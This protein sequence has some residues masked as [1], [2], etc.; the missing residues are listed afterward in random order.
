MI[1]G[2]PGLGN[3]FTY[4]SGRPDS[5]L[6]YAIQ[7]PSGENRP[8]H[9]LCLVVRNGWSSFPPRNGRIHKSLPVSGVSFIT[10]AC[11]P[12]GDTSLS[13]QFSAES[14]SS[15]RPSG[16]NLATPGNVAK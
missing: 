7:R 1:L 2:R 8:T 16:D 4:T 10:R 13:Q 15:A 9:S 12:S 14:I 3:D 5:S 11:F 6:A